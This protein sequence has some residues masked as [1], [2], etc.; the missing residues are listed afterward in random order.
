[1]SQC[2]CIKINGTQCSRKPSEKPT[3]NRLYCWQHQECKISKT[4]ESAKNTTKKHLVV[5]K[6]TKTDAILKK[7]NAKQ[8]IEKK[9]IIG[10]KTIQKKIEK[11]PA[12]K[13]KFSQKPTKKQSSE[14]QI[15]K[16]PAEKTKILQ[17]TIKKQ[18]IE[19]QSIK[20]GPIVKKT[21]KHLD[22]EESIKKTKTLD[23][24]IKMDLY[25]SPI[26][27]QSAGDPNSIIE[28]TSNLTNKYLV[29]FDYT[30]IYEFD[31]N[32]NLEKINGS[33]YLG[34]GT[35]TAVFEVKKIKSSN[36]S[37]PDQ[38]LIVRMVDKSNN[39]NKYIKKW[40]NDKKILPNNIPEIYLYGRIFKNKKIIAVYSLVKKYADESKIRD[41]KFDN[42]I[43][44][45]KKILEA[46]KTLQ[47]NKYTYRDFKMANIGYD[48]DNQG[49]V[50]EFI[51]LDHDDI[52]ILDINDHY[53]DSFYAGC[54]WLCTGTFPPYYIINDYNKKI[55]NWRSRLD[56]MSVLGLCI[57]III[58]FYGEDVIKNHIYIRY[59]SNDPYTYLA[60]L[61]E[62]QD[63]YDAFIKDI[64]DL[65]PIYGS[66]GDNIDTVIKSDLILPLLNQNYEAIPS[67]NKLLEKCNSTFK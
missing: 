15:I 18:D 65:V 12:E 26:F 49:N 21:N 24:P 8:I 20:K 59:F 56:K 3:T 35:Y 32:F 63:K 40:E 22:E 43:I 45:L 30:S 44:F 9:H 6:P 60:R 25:L 46:L 36:D 41:L 11:K 19:D 64:L 2:A 66:L 34:K 29:S 28:S 5:K 4:S 57:V 14:N 53:F 42:K 52:T 23:Q 1:M 10:K 54:N 7:T 39:L 13:T 33:T 67:F 38:N 47:S 37:I 50:K 27:K 16:K 51:V 61:F 17:K 55:S 48:S 62:I 58:L 31:N